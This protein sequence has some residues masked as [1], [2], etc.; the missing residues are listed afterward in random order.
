MPV[1]ARFDFGLAGFSQLCYLCRDDLFPVMNMAVT[2]LPKVRA[3]GR[4]FRVAQ[5]SY[6][7]Y[8]HL[9]ERLQGFLDTL[10]FPGKYRFSYFDR[11]LTHSAKERTVRPAARKA[12]LKEFASFVDALPDNQPRTRIARGPVASD[13]QSEGG[14]LLTTHRTKERK[15]RRAYLRSVPDPY[16]CKVCEIDLGEEYDVQDDYGVIEVHHKLLLATKHKPS[17]DE[18]VGLCPNC[19]A[20]LHRYIAAYLREKQRKDFANRKEAFKV[21]DAFERHCHKSWA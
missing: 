15:N 7:G 14:K 19:H 11:Y 2:P 12:F 8:P 1:T 3:L 20:M 10:R 21:H 13:F 17:P 18:L 5:S 16:R 9:A 4:K 6:Q